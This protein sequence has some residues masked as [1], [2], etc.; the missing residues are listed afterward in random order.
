MPDEG[1]SIDKQ[2]DKIYPQGHICVLWQQPEEVDEI[3]NENN[4][5]QLA[6]RGQ[7]AAKTLLRIGGVEEVARDG[8]EDRYRH[9]E[10]RTKECPTTDHRDVTGNNQEGANGFKYIQ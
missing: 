2:L 5:H 7:S 1:I 6:R 3:D 4:G 9:I 8:V 10:K